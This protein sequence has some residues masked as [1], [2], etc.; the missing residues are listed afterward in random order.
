MARRHVLSEGA[1]KL[2]GELC[3]RT[4][5]TGRSD[6]FDCDVAIIGSGYG[7]SVAAARLAGAIDTRTGKSIRVYLLERGLEHPAGTFPATFAELMGHVRV[8]AGNWFKPKGTATGLFDLRVGP[9]MQALVGNGLGG[10]SLINAGVLEVPHRTVLKDPAWPAEIQWRP[11]LQACNTVRKTIAARRIPDRGALSETQNQQQGDPNAPGL[12]DKTIALRLV[13]HGLGMAGRFFRTRIAVTFAAERNRQGVDQQACIACGD[14]FSG[15]NFGAKNT[16]D[17]NYLVQAHSRGARLFTGATVLQL[18]PDGTGWNVRF[19]FTDPQISRTERGPFKLRARRVIV[20]AGTFGSTELLLKSRSSGLVFSRQLGRGFTGN[21]DTIAVAYRQQQRVNAAPKETTA[22]RYRGVGATITGMIDLRNLE[23]GRGPV[24]QELAVP[25]ALR[26]LFEEVV[27]NSA[28]FR[29]FAD[30]DFSRRSNAGWQPDPLAHD[31]DSLEHTAI[32][33]IMGHD[34]PGP[35]GAES[36]GPT[37][38]ARRA[39]HGGRQGGRIRLAPVSRRDDQSDGHVTVHWPDLHKPAMTAVVQKRLQLLQRA[40]ADSNVGGTVIANPLWQAFP[41]ELASLI[42]NGARGP[43]VT[44]HPLGGCRMG[45]SFQDGVVNAWGQVYRPDTPP[46]AMPAGDPLPGGSPPGQPAL[47]EGLVVLDGSIMPT[48]LGINPSLAIAALAELAIPHLAAQWELQPADATTPLAAQ[49]A[50]PIVARPAASPID[51]PPM[52]AIDRIAEGTAFSPTAFN[53]SERMLGDDIIVRAPVQP[54]RLAMEL[55]LGPIRDIAQ[56]MQHADRAVPISASRMTIVATPEGGDPAN[57][58]PVT[59]HVT[60]DVQVLRPVPSN[61]ILRTLRGFSGFAL[62][63]IIRDSGAMDWWPPRELWKSMLGLAKTCSVIG[64]RREFRYRMRVMEHVHLGGRRVFAAGDELIGIKSIAYGFRSN[65][66][67]QVTTLQLYHQP[68][69]G[70]CR[71][72]L[73][74]LT[75]DSLYFAFYENFL[76]RVARQA[77]LMNALGDFASFM[78]FC[79]RVFLNVHFSSFRAPEYPDPIRLAP[80]PADLLPESLGDG[81]QRSRHLLVVAASAKSCDRSSITIDL[82]RYQSRGRAQRGPLLLIHGLGAAGNTF[83][84]PTIESNLARHLVDAGFDVWVVDLRT[85][86]ASKWSM[87]GW[88]FDDAALCD[89]PAAVDQILAATGA[90]RI[91]VV[92]HC[93]GAAMFSMAVLMGRLDGKIRRAVLSQVGLAVELSPYNVARG[94]LL[95]VFKNLLPAARVSSAIN[96]TPGTA[97]QLVDR[98]LSTFPYPRDE[99]FRHHPWLPTWLLHDPFEAQYN[100]IS[101]IYGQLFNRRNMQRATLRQLDRM[102]R[103]VDV[104]TYAQTLYYASLQRLTDRDGQPLVTRDR[105]NAHY[106]FPVFFVSGGDNRV[107]DCSTAPE[108]LELLQSARGGHDGLSQAR[109]VPGYG[110]QDTMIGKNAYRDVFPLI[111]SFLS[112]ADPAP[113]KLA[114]TTRRTVY[115][116]VLGPVLGWLRRGEPADPDGGCLARLMFAHDPTAGEPEFLVTLIEAAG[117]AGETTPIRAARAG[118]FYRA[119]GLGLAGQ[120]VRYLDLPLPADPVDWRVIVIAVH[121]QEVID[122]NSCEL[123]STLPCPGAGAPAPGQCLAMNEPQ[124]AAWVKEVNRHLI[125]PN[126]LQRIN[127]HRVLRELGLHLSD[128]KPRFASMRLS[129]AAI[130]AADRGVTPLDGPAC[131]GRLCFALASCQYASLIVDRAV[132]ADSFSR[133]AARLDNGIDSADKPALMLL[134]GDQI[135]ADATAGYFDDRSELEKYRKPYLS[136]WGNTGVRAAV[137]RLPIYPILDDHEIDDNWEPPTGASAEVALDTYRTYQA[138][139]TPVSVT[140]QAA[141]QQY[142][143]RFTPGGLPFFVMDTRTARARRTISNFATAQIADDEQFNALEA[144]LCAQP[145]ALPKFIASPSVV[146]PFPN[147]TD[148]DPSYCLRADGWAGFPASIARLV[149]IIARH[150]IGKVVFLSGDYHMGLVARLKIYP[151]AD[152][153]PLL[154][155]SIVASGLY[156]PLPFVNTRAAHLVLRSG[157][158]SA[159]GGVAFEYEVLSRSIIEQ[160][161]FAVVTALRSGESDHWN[162][163]VDFDSPNGRQSIGID[164]G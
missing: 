51:P 119:D 164:L 41:D 5:G 122:S 2:V 139:L 8:S 145:A 115:A 98:L 10:G 70:A 147:V 81:Y 142:W 140:P 80:P 25:A 73:G 104:S 36:S 107:F 76:I 91:D 23:H 44:V 77:N 133:L 28:F 106:D 143:Y 110:H 29:R 54:A 16:L 100:R 86:I 129:R 48:S 127:H 158:L 55:S 162:L 134:L 99:W 128:P 7:G 131:A 137:S 156:A 82:T 31:D 11:F 95:S 160:E 83:T 151:A 159:G 6:A 124:L 117:I 18:Q 71:D 56:L 97:M 150:R 74:T 38:R 64:E 12:P 63:R 72:Y 94:H 111:S 69:G 67:Q 17:R 144:W 68:A 30:G 123:D 49:R 102:I 146:F 3:D 79:S 116:S 138:G 42:A 19:T 62:N 14:C 108:S 52:R 33:A 60:G 132:S 53:L 78:T 37:R 87:T 59:F 47:Y 114:R 15:C 109:V 58:R 21:G 57:D 149:G 126:G 88:T 61:S 113:R 26:R 65:P 157:K 20:A 121:D 154:A 34:G 22:P 35:A 32:Y 120:G 93:I 50:A 141:P 105:L 27:T 90:H 24:I 89:I 148:G 84:T 39:R 66:W 85:S 9:D 155:H 130:E 96:R 92:A 153:P 75:T 112:A 136:L 101:G 118:C 163:N 13:A 4:G 46:G 152:Q 125:S 43:S 103:H 45:R 135:Y 161:H 1:E 40:H